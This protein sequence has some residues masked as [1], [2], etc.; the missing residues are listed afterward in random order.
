MESTVLPEKYKVPFPL[1]YSSI[2][3]QLELTYPGFK[4]IEKTSISEY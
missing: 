2:T 3:L 4:E 1:L